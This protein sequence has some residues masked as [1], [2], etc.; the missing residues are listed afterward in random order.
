MSTLGKFK[1]E[2]DDV[3]HDFAEWT[4]DKTS[5][6]IKRE[7]RIRLKEFWDDQPWYLRLLKPFIMRMFYRTWKGIIK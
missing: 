7:M 1:D 5:D 3:I 2:Y 6:V 4:K